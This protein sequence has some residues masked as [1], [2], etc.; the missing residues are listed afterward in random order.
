[1]R[2]P[3]LLP[4]SSVLL[5]RPRAVLFDWDNTLAD[6]WSVIGAA[7]N[8]TFAIWGLPLWSQAEIDANIRA[9][10]R[11]AFPRI[12]GPRW[13]EARAHYY[14]AFEAEHLERLRPLPGA[15]D[16][17]SELSGNGIYL[18]L[19]SNKTGRYLRKEAEHLGFDRHLAAMIGANDAPADK[20]DPAPVH[21]ALQGS[22]IVAGADVWFVGDAAIDMQC[23]HA[24]GCR[25]ILVGTPKPGDDFSTAP[26]DLHV[27]DLP[28][29]ANFIRGLA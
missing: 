9:S 15:E 4:T 19:V 21:L 16:L 10:L 3:S 1:M 28:F 12:F 23:A 2:E 14:R 20:P 24:C 22:D 13:E 17:L 11:D 5:S 6:N 7:L 25:A 29:L 18:A 26:P 27:P 8:A